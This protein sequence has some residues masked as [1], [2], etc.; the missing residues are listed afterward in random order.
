[1]FTQLNPTEI[2]LGHLRTLG[3]KDLKN[4]DT[5]STLPTLLFLSTGLPFAFLQ[6]LA[7]LNSYFLTSEIVGTIVSAAS[8]IAGLLLNLLVLIYT[9][10]VN[11]LK[12]LEDSREL[13]KRVAL[14]TFYNIS[15]TVLASLLLVLV[16][17]MCL[18]NNPTIRV[19]GNISTFYI[20]PLVAVSLLMVLKKCHKLINFY[21]SKEEF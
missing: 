1:M 3:K 13:F 16:S 4:K 2:V 18:A 21:L 8:I 17:L 7:V 19:I 9:L 10:V 14:H 5:I 12:E 6:A 11:H 20:G 15:F